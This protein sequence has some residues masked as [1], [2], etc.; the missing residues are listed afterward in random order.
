MY[1]NPYPQSVLLVVFVYYSSCYINT[2]LIGKV[3]LLAF[4]GISNRESRLH[5]EVI[6]GI[7][8]HY[9][10]RIQNPYNHYVVAGH[11]RIILSSECGF[12]LGL[13]YMIRPKT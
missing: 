8:E 13:F 3:T 2:V 10:D 9:S 1:L 12:G 4:S 7:S 11:T 5:Y 6:I